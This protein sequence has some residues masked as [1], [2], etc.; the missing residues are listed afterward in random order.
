MARYIMIRLGQAVL[1]IFLILTLT[2]VLARMAG[3]PTA[4]LLPPETNAADAAAYKHAIGLDKPLGTQYV[5]YIVGALHLD[6][7]KSL[8]GGGPALDFVTSR[9]P[10]TL[11]LAGA[12]LVVSL[13][14]ALGLGLTIE[15]TSSKRIRTAILSAALVREAIPAFVFGL[16]LIIVFGVKLEWLPFIGKN[17]PKSFVLPVLTLSSVTLSLYLRILRSSFAQERSQDYVRTALAKGSSRWHIVMREAFP[18]VLLPFVTTVAVNIG[19]LIVGSVLVETV[20]SWPGMAF[21]MVQAVQQRDF[22]VIQAGVILIATV[23]VLINLITDIVCSKLDPRI[24][25]IA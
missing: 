7:G 18:N 15:L 19:F 25:L 21:A 10:A 17:G 16:L 9:L 22:P 8:R 11:E 3:D 24:A 5:N 14:L 1:T 20:F 12:S 2:F 23:F 6:F 4:L 13:I